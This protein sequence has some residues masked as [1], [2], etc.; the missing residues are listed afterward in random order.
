MVMASAEIGKEVKSAIVTHSPLLSIVVPVYNGSK[1]IES[2]LQ[3]LKFRIE[4]LQPFVA[5]I[6]IQETSN[7]EV[8]TGR[9]V[10]DEASAAILLDTYLSTNPVEAPMGID[11]D[12][13]QANKKAHH[14]ANWYEIIVVNDGSKDDT[15]NVM[16]N[17]CSIDESIRLISYG[18]NMGKGYAIK[19]GVL[20][21]R[22]KFV[23]FLDGDGEISTEVLSKYLEQL[24]HAD[25]VIASKYHPESVV[26]VPI[27][28]KFFSKCFH[29]FVKALLGVKVSDTQ[30]GLKIGDGEKFR[31]IFEKVLV[32]RYAF[33]AEMLA[34]A[35][36]LRLRIVELPV[37]IDLD[38]SF[39]KKEI[40]KMALDILGVAYRLRIL[41]WYQRNMERQRP[42]YRALIS[43]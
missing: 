3:N 25:M 14:L 22:G 1:K 4:K 28:R 8:Y 2:T 31:K 18:T 19:Q 7:Q 40:M 13:D 35:E 32:K 33:D 17:I 41:R 37:K 16:N 6:E 29:L 9:K 38:K 5:G 20:H 36:I 15:R 27:S 24:K 39:K 21:S 34:I 12:R 10:I 23:M 26:K 11:L 42:I 30:V 43:A